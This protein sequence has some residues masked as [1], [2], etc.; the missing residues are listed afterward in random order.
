MLGLLPR[1]GEGVYISTY[2]YG[3]ENEHEAKNYVAYGQHLARLVRRDL[4]VS[5]AEQYDPESSL[6][7][8][9]GYRRSVIGSCSQD[10]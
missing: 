2:R 1:L 9:T 7:V 3:R 5:D 6:S 8:A 4:D 10:S